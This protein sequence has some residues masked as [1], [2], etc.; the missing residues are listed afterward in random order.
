MSTGVLRAF[1]RGLL[2]QL[3]PS[4]L[5]LLVVP[6]GVA[7]VFWA[8]AAWFVWDPLTAWLHATLFAGDGWLRVVFDWAG[9]MGLQGLGGALSVVIAIMV[10]APLMFVTAM[11]L[12]AVL[13]MP[14][15]NRHLSNGPYRDV[16]RR[17]GWSVGASVWNALSST[18]LF[19]V[20]Y[21]ATMPLWLIPPLALIVPWLWWSWLTAR[22]MRFDSLVEHADPEERTALIRANRRSYLLL[23]L[24][25]T[26]LNYVPPLFLITPVLSALCFGHFSLS[27]LRER[28]AATSLTPG[29]GPGMVERIQPGAPTPLPHRR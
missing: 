23:S 10:L 22:V 19:L 16:V 24:A 13:A 5:A 11:L 4:M 26:A 1:G 3:H 28:R 18:L 17:G 6:F 9:R 27:V 20:G 15:V 21:V 25:V 7:V 29:A 14:V 2:S 12:V 8:L